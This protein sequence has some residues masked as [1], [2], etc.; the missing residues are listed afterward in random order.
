[1]YEE[2]GRID[3][4][5]LGAKFLFSELL[6]SYSEMLN[7]YCMQEVSHFDKPPEVNISRNLPKT[8]E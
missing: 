8:N 4:W 2:K 1:M 3:V 5:I 7:A 6:S